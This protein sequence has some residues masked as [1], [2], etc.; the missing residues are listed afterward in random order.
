MDAFTTEARVRAKFALHDASR[1]PA[2][3]IEV[4]IA[5]A[6]T[7]IQRVIDPAVDLAGPLVEDL[8]PGLVLGETL[9]AGARLLETLAAAEA[10]D[11]QRVSLGSRR[12][13]E[14][15]R[16]RDLLAAAAVAENRALRALEAYVVRTPVRGAATTTDTQ[17]TVG[18]G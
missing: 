15:S 7:E 5:D 14:S 13:E 6:H 9:L 4:A 1:L 8:P 2:E 16:H 3:T 18:E 10:F 17:P 11:Q 12:I